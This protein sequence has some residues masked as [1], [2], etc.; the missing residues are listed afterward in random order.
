MPIA[1]CVQLPR[2]RLGITDNTRVLLSVM[3]CAEGKIRHVGNMIGGKYMAKMK[4]G[5]QNH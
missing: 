5:L 4:L 3:M 2:A 1:V